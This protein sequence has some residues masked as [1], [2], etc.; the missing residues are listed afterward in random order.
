M[1][2]IMAK[3]IRREELE[4]IIEE[5][6]T[7]SLDK[8]VVVLLSDGVAT[9]RLDLNNGEVIHADGSMAD[10]KNEEVKVIIK[11]KK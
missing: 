8:P 4:R 9:V 3:K 6:L 5:A 2:T 11:E 10:L 1:K 7:M